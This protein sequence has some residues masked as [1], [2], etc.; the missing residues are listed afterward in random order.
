MRKLVFATVGVALSAFVGISLASA[1]QAADTPTLPF[2]LRSLDGSANNTMHRDWGRA[3]TQ[4]PRVARANYTD[5]IARPVT[6]PPAR[7]LSNRIF[8]D[9]GQNIFSENDVSQW[10][11]A[12][13]QF[14]DN[15]MDLRDETAA[16]SAP[17]PF[18]ARDPL[19][20]FKNDSG[21]MAFS[22]TPAA[23]GTGTGRSNPRQQ[24]NTDT[25]FIDASQ[26]Y[27]SSDSRLA[28]LKSGNGVDLFMPGNYLPHASAKPGAPPMDLMGQLAGN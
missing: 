12:W 24:V 22:R 14:I 6:G 13:G 26:V 16:E 28:W 8:N 27:G 25:S 17:M 20:Q 4:Y 11:W 5:G 9:L 7:Y 1:P 21:Q 3:G 23:P 2:E 15:D 19:E 18:D 10:G